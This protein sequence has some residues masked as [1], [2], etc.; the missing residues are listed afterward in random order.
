MVAAKRSTI[1]H[2]LEGR[3]TSHLLPHVTNRGIG[4]V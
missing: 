3:V 1:A 4:L 2:D